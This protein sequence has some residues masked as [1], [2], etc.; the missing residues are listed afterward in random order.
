[1]ELVPSSYQNIFRFVIGLFA[2]LFVSFSVLVILTNAGNE[3]MTVN[4]T[5]NAWTYFYMERLMSHRL[6]F[7]IFWTLK[8]FITTLLIFVNDSY[9]CTSVP[10]E[11]NYL[12]AK[13]NS[14][15]HQAAHA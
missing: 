13:S 7:L 12:L 15:S 2:S 5:E 1:M 14:L 4:E 10:W 11:A 8:G 9:P 6:P 3:L